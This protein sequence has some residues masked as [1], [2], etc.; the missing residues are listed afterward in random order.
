[1]RDTKIERPKKINENLSDPQKVAQKF[2]ST[3][4]KDLTKFQIQK[5]GPTSLSKF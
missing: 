3:E 5:I 4:K 1:M 2:A